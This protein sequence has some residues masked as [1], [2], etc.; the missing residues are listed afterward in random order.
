M[1]PCV[2]VFHDTGTASHRN[3]LEEINNVN[4]TVYT[5]KV[6]VPDYRDLNQDRMEGQ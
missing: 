5:S 4:Q 2:S 3:L 6:Y 1:P